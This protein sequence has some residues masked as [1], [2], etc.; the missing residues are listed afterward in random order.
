[1]EEHDSDVQEL[2]SAIIKEFRAHATCLLILNHADILNLDEKER[3]V[4]ALSW[5]HGFDGLYSE[6]I[7]T[8]VTSGK[9]LDKC[10]GGMMDLQGLTYTFV[11]EEIIHRYFGK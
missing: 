9:P 1:M 8:L 5:E 3:N 11:D 6:Q 4:H 2:G 7:N 10:T